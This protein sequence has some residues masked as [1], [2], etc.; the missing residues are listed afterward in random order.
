MILLASF[1]IQALSENLCM[2]L[3]SS[4]REALYTKKGKLPFA[5]SPFL[6][7]FNKRSSNG[8]SPNFPKSLQNIEYWFPNI[9]LVQI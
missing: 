9:T 7:F 2:F 1:Q 3:N 8:S 4:I 6:D 5:P